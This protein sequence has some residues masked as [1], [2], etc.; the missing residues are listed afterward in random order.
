ML[1]CYKVNAGYSGSV[2]YCTGTGTALVKGLFSKSVTSHVVAWV[3]MWV[4][5]EMWLSTCMDVRLW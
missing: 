4:D 5:D 3:C 1:R 2:Y